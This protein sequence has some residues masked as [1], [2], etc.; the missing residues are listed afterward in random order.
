MYTLPLL[1]KSLI[2]VIV[3]V[4]VVVAVADV[5]VVDVDVGLPTIKSHLSFSSCRFIKVSL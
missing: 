2:N 5:V 3:V 1:P 4:T